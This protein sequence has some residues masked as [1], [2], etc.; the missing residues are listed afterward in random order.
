MNSTET[1]F[2][3][4]L[5]DDF[6]IWQHTD[7]LKPLPEE[8]YALDDA[9]RGLILCLLLGREEQAGVLFNYL[10]ASQKDGRFY[11]FATD[12]RQFI[13]YPSS[14][15]AHA[16]VI[17]AMGVA[18]NHG[19]RKDEALSLIQLARPAV[20]EMRWI[21]GFAYA[22]LGAVYCD[23]EW[24]AE[25][26]AKVADRC[27]G[28][29]DDWFWPEEQMTYGNAIIP[30]ALLRY[31]LVTGD[32]QYLELAKKLLAFLEATC[33]RDRQFGPVGND[34]WASK[35]NPAVALYS[36]QP[37]DAAY[38]VWA[39]LVLHQIGREERDLNLAREWM[40]WFEGKNVAGQPMINP[41]NNQCYDGIDPGGINRHSGAES[42]ICYLISAKAVE[43]QLTF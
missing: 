7:G 12:G 30:Y 26:A 37:I 9:T 22:L 16:Q 20:S 18:A 24:A 27:D 25:L 19:F 40:S 38:M 11:G 14:E 31:S 42:N 13:D 21:R 17:W 29:S 43:S 28:L 5:I 2:F 6:G 3:D 34:G 35:G 39:Y 33:R 36:Q 1:T 10:K 8:G 23:K 15:D 4:T 32:G 41:E